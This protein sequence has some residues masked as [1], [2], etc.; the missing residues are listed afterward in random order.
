LREAAPIGTY[1]LNRGKGSR[2]FTETQ[3]MN[4]THIV[5]VAE[6]L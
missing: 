4:E 3:L 2:A 5:G 1:G 6:P